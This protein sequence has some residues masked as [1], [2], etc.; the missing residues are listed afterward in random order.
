MTMNFPYAKPADDRFARYSG[1]A[2]IAAVLLAMC[3]ALLVA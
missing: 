2:V 3:S 1:F